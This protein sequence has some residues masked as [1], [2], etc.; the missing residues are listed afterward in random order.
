MNPRSPELIAGRRRNLATKDH[1]EH[2]E[3]KNGLLSLH[4]LCDPLWLKALMD[5]EFG[6]LGHEI[7]SKLCPS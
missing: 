6:W 2:N 4:A 7:K 1:K 5:W 3:Y